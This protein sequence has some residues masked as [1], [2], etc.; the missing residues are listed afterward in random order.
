[1]RKKKSSLDKTLPVELGF[2]LASMADLLNSTTRVKRTLVYDRFGRVIS[3]TEPTTSSMS[4]DK[5]KTRTS[6]VEYNELGQISHVK[7]TSSVVRADLTP[8]SEEDKKVVEVT[9]HDYDK[10]GR[11]IGTRKDTW[12][13]DTP[14]LTTT[15][16]EKVEYDTL[17]RKAR[18]ETLIK[19]EGVD[20]DAKEVSNLEQDA[21]GNL[22]SYEY[23]KDGKVY[24]VSNI[25]YH[26]DGPNQG[27]VASYIVSDGTDTI[28]YSD[29]TYDENGYITSFTKT[30]PD[31]TKEYHTI[32]RDEDGEVTEY[33]IRDE[34][35]QVISRFVL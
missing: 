11:T 23:T 31:G 13:S 16:A 29:I 28:T 19:K 32:T 22:T 25:T 30:L 20:I 2:I 4:P 17:G 14:A 5:V 35:G 24:H 34:N 33:I 27:R 1:M 15:S 9:S 18:T 7:S 12:D 8:K 6:R 10:H 21:D 26:E 3:K